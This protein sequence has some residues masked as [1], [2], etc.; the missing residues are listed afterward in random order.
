MPPPLASI[1]KDRIA[2]HL[3]Q[4]LSPKIIADF[5][6]VDAITVRKI[7]GRLKTWGQ[8]SSS[9]KMSA[10]RPTLLIQV[11]KAWLRRHY[12]LAEDMSFEAYLHM[13]VKACSKG[14]FAAGHFR[15]AS[16]TV[17]IDTN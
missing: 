8:H 1:Q 9:N 2:V 6:E 5:E 15:H 17:N 11:L 13:A 7:R 4:R 16:I 10:L 12:K 3:Q 14:H